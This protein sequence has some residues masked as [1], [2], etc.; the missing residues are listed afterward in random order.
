MYF[1]NFLLSGKWNRFLM[2]SSGVLNTNV[3]IA[4]YWPSSQKNYI[5]N[6][7]TKIVVM[8]I[9]TLQILITLQ[10]ILKIS[11]FPCALTPLNHRYVVVK[12]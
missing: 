1:I 2:D 10:G 6:K 3:P 12:N 8:I 9:A 4:L 5:H 11:L 7:D